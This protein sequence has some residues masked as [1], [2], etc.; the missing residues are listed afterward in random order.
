[1]FGGTLTIENR[2]LLKFYIIL[3]LIQISK[4]LNVLNISQNTK[5]IPG[6]PLKSD[7]QIY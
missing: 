3:N 1:M 6:L 7:N 2:P 5:G 4:Y